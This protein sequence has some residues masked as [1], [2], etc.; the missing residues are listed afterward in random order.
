MVTPTE[1]SNRPR[2]SSIPAPSSRWVSATLPA[3]TRNPRATVKVPVSLA[4]PPVTLSSTTHRWPNQTMA[5][6]HC[7][8][9]ECRV[10]TARSPTHRCF[11]GPN[12]NLMVWSVWLRA[13]LSQARCKE[14]SSTSA[15]EP[16]PPS[17][18]PGSSPRNRCNQLETICHSRGSSGK[19]RV[20]LRVH[21]RL[22]RRSR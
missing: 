6:C 9:S 15:K 20:Q 2:S 12:A 11:T 8:S 13:P 5:R 14:Y 19:A 18:P 16:S 4:S 1:A 21:F 10:A 22:S 3:A 17:R 7:S